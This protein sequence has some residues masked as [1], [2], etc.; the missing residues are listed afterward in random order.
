LPIRS[1]YGAT[2]LALVGVGALFLSSVALPLVTYTTVLALFGLPHIASELRY[3]DYRFGVRLG[4]STVLRLVVLLVL[5]MGARATGL[6][7][8]LPFPVAGAIE[9]LLAALAVLTLVQAGSFVRWG[10][11]ALC[12]LLVACALV[13]PLATL[14][15]LAVSH[16][17]TPI[18]FLAER[19][20]G[21]ERRRA[22]VL[23][24]TGLVLLP[25]LI[26]TGLPFDWL[27]ALGLGNPDATA[28][29][30]AG[31]LLA[32]LGAYV[33]SWAMGEDWALHAFSASV[34]AQCMHYVAV[35][36][37]LPRLIPAEARPLVGWPKAQTFWLI[38][39]G[40]G[41]AAFA[42]FAADYLLVRKFYAIVALL[43]AWLEIPLLLLAVQP[44][45]MKPRQMKLA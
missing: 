6:F 14:L 21:R 1:A 17:L 41:V 24:A 15:F 16:N 37:V 11:I 39:A 22:L 2:A 42:G 38:V 3:L 33:P 40:A 44:P 25:G 9:I 31:D 29:P 10:A 18:G 28:F 36:G 19:L 20:R 12:L 26:A 45:Q 30:A 32:N 23:A 5:A 43:H 8:A 4:R 7:Q 35:I 27:S 34:F 13:A